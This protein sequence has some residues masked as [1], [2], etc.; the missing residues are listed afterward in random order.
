[1]GSFKI[2]GK[3]RDGYLAKGTPDESSAPDI[4]DAIDKKHLHDNKVELDLVSDG[5]HD[6]RT[7]NPHGVTGITGKTGPTGPQGIT[8]AGVTG[9]TGPTGIQ[10]STGPTGAGTT[11][12]TGPEGPQGETGSTGPTGAGVTGPTGIQGM[13]GPQG[14]IGPTGPSFSP[15]YIEDDTVS[16]TTNT[17]WQQKLRMNFTPPSV[18]DYFLEWAVEI[19]NSKLAKCT[20]IQ[21]ELDDTTQINI[22]VACPS[23]AGEYKAYSAFKKINFADTNLH[24]VDVDF[25]A[26]SDTASIRRVRLSMT[27]L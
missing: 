15:T 1:M 13:T 27:K 19:S 6:I 23:M 4:K 16:S 2:H 26:E 14:E 9:P 10:G 18:G 8:G 7:D 25:K 21:V 20:Y 5:N 12:P 24:T 11:G 3:D 17:N 22:V